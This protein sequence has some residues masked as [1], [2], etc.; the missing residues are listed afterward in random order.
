MYVRIIQA[1]ERV[2]DEELGRNAPDWRVKNACP[3]CAYE[4]RIVADVL[5][6][7]T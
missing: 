1:V 4:E 6:L 3:P 5:V 7:Y 2:V